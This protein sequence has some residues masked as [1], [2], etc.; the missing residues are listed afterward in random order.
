MTPSNNEQKS[1]LT[2]QL[3][4]LSHEIATVGVVFSLHTVS[5]FVVMV[6]QA[7]RRQFFNSFLV[8]DNRHTIIF[9]TYIGVHCVEFMLIEAGRETVRNS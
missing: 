8:Y 7:F 3:H 2:K 5:F 1:I 9:E 4:S 6:L